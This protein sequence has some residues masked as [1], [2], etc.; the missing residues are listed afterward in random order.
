MARD[1]NGK[2][3]IARQ[4]DALQLAE[5]AFRQEFEMYQ[6]QEAEKLTT[7][8]VEHE[9]ERQLWEAAWLATAQQVQH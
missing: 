6:S 1:D 3:P 5:A 7:L 8:K 2:S 9:K 4:V